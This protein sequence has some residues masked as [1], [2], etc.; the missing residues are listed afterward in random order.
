MT[1]ARVGALPREI[2]DIDIGP[3]YPVGMWPVPGYWGR[4]LFYRLRN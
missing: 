4:I 3:G 1:E 2:L